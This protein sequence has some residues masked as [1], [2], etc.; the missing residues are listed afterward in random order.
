M[1]VETALFRSRPPPPG[2][3][4]I[5]MDGNGRW[6]SARG[7][8]HAAGHARGAEVARDTVQA[9][10]ELG[11]RFLTLYG[12]SS[13]N[14]GRPR[15]EVESILGLLRR[16]L[17][18][19]VESLHRSGVRLAMIGDRGSLPPD[20]RRQIERAERLTQE[21]DGIRVQIAFGYG[22]RDEI[23]RAARR[24]VREARAGGEPVEDIDE[25]ALAARLDTAGIP[26]PDLM[27]RTGGE[28]RISNFLLWQAAYAELVF[29]DRLWPDFTRAD[30]E[31][32]LGEFARR[33][34]RYGTRAA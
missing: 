5:T 31:A 7:L 4:A 28:M 3:V 22:G 33:E 17:G 14:W 13:E 11:V 21:N 19:E 20:L 16:Y 25:D 1:A 29:T 15:E 34:R 10:A 12:F 6:A 30:L 24:L 23:V 8:S 9:A 27:I 2:H 32:A 18:E 26:D